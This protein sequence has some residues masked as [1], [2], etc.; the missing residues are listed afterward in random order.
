[1]VIKNAVSIICFELPPNIR[2]VGAPHL[3]LVVAAPCNMLYFIFILIYSLHELP[4]SKTKINLV[5]HHSHNGLVTITKV[6]IHLRLFFQGI[7]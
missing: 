1:M 5:I 6:K 3:D 7:F 2:N 4:F